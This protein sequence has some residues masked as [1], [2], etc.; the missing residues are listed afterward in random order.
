[1]KSFVAPP[2]L[3]PGQT[4]CL[5][6]TARKI[7]PDDVALALKIF[8][9]WGLQV[10]QGNHLFA[11]SGQFAGT[12]E[13]RTADFQNALN[14]PHTHAIICARG[15]Y[16]TTR[17]LD[18]LD[19]QQFIK[20]PKWIAGFSDITALHSQLHHLQVQSLHSTMPICFDTDAPDTVESLRKALFGEALRYTARPHLLNRPGNA[21]GLATGG[22]LSVLASV[23]GTASDVD[24]AG[25]ILFLE[26]TD[27]Y[28]Y[29]LDRMVIQLKRAGK[30]RNLAGLVVGSFS[31]IHDNGVPF[32]KNT[33]EIVAEAV[34]DYS[35][36][37]CFNFPTG[38]TP[39][40]VTLPFGKRALLKVTASQT[41][42]TFEDN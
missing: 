22:N 25:K 39:H 37:V 13:E 31:N 29:H 15:G 5:V 12:D 41:T 6:S 19:F 34:A 33:E 14:D 40:N 23:I 17:I 21:T 27:E 2:L 30:L 32:G 10:K 24:T 42:L 8:E 35:F 3:Q 20:K 16:G 11:E 1:M 38:H 9:Q 36:P 26:D 4:V 28:L 7:H 18:S